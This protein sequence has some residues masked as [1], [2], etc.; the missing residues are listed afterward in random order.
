MKIVFK[1]LYEI[2][3][4]VFIRR[5]F[6]KWHLFLFEIAV[7][8]MGILNYDDRD[9]R[10]GEY[11]FM[12]WLASKLKSRVV[13]D[14][15]ANEG[16]YSLQAATIIQDIEI[17]AFEPNEKTF[18]CLER[19]LSGLENVH[20]VNEACGDK[21]EIRPLYDYQNDDASTHATLYRQV[22]EEVH[23]KPAVCREV[24]VTTI[25][26]YCRLLGIDRIG[27]L[28]ID[29]EGNEFHT[30]LGAKEMIERNVIEFIHFEFNEMNIYSR[31][32]LHDFLS[33]L[34]NFEFFR[35]LPDGMVPLGKYRALTHELF[36]YQNIVAVRREGLCC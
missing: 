27:L 15:G 2:Y 19:N 34:R 7:R 18:L 5:A 23:A 13:I 25:D 36:A 8:G 29:T 1:A 14:V 6:Y 4:R 22:I 31:V 26:E 12:K 9:G 21:C 10:S 28:K 17:H 30:L 33:L 11:A 32:Y 20:L 35:L 16:R 3:W 24:S